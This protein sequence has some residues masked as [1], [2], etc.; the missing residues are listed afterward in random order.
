[1]LC[2][3]Y[4]LYRGSDS[5]KIC[6]VIHLFFQNIIEVVNNM[7]PVH[8]CYP[9][10]NINLCSERRKVVCCPLFGLTLPGTLLLN[11]LPLTCAAMYAA[12]VSK[13]VLGFQIQLH[14]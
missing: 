3:F 2:L 7:M 13:G 6:L 14:S 8:Y 5:T 12:P 1:M 9:H 4:T 11:E 10:D